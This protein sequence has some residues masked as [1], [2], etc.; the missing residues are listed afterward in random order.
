MVQ[1]INNFS[2]IRTGLRCSSKASMTV[3][4]Q[5]YIVLLCQVGVLLQVNYA[6]WIN[7]EFKEQNVPIACRLK[8]STNSNHISILSK[9]I[10]NA[11]ILLRSFICTFLRNSH[12]LSGFH[13]SSNTLNLWVKRSVV[14][15][16]GEFQI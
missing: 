2:T 14:R 9:G 6:V 5:W 3:A 10:S 13:I 7:L 4:I 11:T 1:I 8:K 15:R 16:A 12:S